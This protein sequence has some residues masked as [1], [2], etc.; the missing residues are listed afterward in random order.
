MES[1]CLGD[2][3][4]QEWNVSRKELQELV[5]AGVLT[6]AELEEVISMEFNTVSISTAE[7]AHL[8][9][10]V[11]WSAVAYSDRLTDLG[12]Y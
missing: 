11:F 3:R 10:S 5:E 7:I 1:C 2:Q 9:F 8:I 4:V 6:D 12:E